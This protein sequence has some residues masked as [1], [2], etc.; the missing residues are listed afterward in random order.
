MSA[1][2]KYGLRLKPTLAGKTG[3]TPPVLHV[4]L[5]AGHFPVPSDNHNGTLT[6]MGAIFFVLLMAGKGFPCEDL[7]PGRHFS[8]SFPSYASYSGMPH[9]PRTLHAQTSNR[10]ASTDPAGMDIVE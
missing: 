1:L 6:E 5:L 4:L 8:A 3:L 2:T 7:R 10:N 9:S